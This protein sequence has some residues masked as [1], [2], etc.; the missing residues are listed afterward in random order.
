M[1]I[2]DLERPSVNY[3]LQRGLEISLLKLEGKRLG[4]WCHPEGCHGDV[5][6]RALKEI[7][8][9]IGGW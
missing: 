2:V 7:K 1:E 5:L 9:G 3:G 6:V 8:A 4:C